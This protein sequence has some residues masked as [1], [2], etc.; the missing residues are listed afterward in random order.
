[1]EHL[2]GVYTGK[3]ATPNCHGQEKVRR[4]QAWLDKTYGPQN[5][6]ALHA[7]GDTSG[8]KPMLCMADTAWY[9]GKPWAD[10]RNYG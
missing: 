3:M 4:L 1:M 8:D 2:N 7:Y 10:K 9:R 5:T 6:P